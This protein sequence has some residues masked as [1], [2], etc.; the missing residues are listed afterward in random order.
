MI[1]MP[2]NE[3]LW[4]DLEAAAFLKLSPLTLRKARMSGGGPPYL[5]LGHSVRYL[6][7]SVRDWCAERAQRSTSE[8][9]NRPPLTLQPSIG[10]P[11]RP[12]KI[13]TDAATA[14]GGDR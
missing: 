2:P 1:A 9:Q 6:P 12:C 5:K 3:S 8:Q 4:D 13:R 10:G 11:G 14:E 7:S